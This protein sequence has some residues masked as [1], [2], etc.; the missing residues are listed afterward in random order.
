MESLL[1]KVVKV[2]NKVVDA[3]D[4]KKLKEEYN[5]FSYQ[6]YEHG[7]E[8]KMYLIEGVRC[9]I[10]YPEKYKLE[11]TIIYTHGGGYV[12]PLDQNHFRFCS[13]ICREKGMKIYMVDYSLAPYRQFPKAMEE[14]IA[15]YKYILKTDYPSNIYFMGDS[16]GGGLALGT[17]L[18]LKDGGEPLP[19][20]IILLSPWLDITM[21]NP[22]IEDVQKEDNFL[23]LD[24]L[25]ECAANY[26]GDEDR[27]NPYISPMYGD[28]KGLPPIVFHVGTDDIL[29]PDCFLFRVKADKEGVDVTYRV[30][31]DMIHNF[32][33]LPFVPE[34]R[35][36]VEQ[37]IKDI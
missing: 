2:M 33:L 29:Y 3:E 28:Y 16:A 8:I 9:F 31:E 24:Y 18:K 7:C 5:E 22:H 32:M 1:S 21:T 20:K 6:R 35:K 4:M 14:V 36:A 25:D 11:R 27:K 23:T 10:F 17:V 34:A 15:V 12:G 30:W 13:R 19:S 37:I 26:A